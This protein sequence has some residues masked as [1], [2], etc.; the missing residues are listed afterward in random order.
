MEIVAAGR[1]EKT[2]QAQ[3]LAG[4]HFAFDVEMRGGI[5]ADQNGGKTGAHAGRAQAG[6]LVR[7]FGVDLIADG[8]AVKDAGSHAASTG[9]GAG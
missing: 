3:L 2:F 5:V 4:G 7:Q 8:V 9:V 1:S 6:D